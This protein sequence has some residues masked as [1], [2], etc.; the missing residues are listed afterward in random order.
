MSD[1]GNNE[2]ENMQDENHEPAANAQTLVTYLVKALVED[3]DAVKVDV[4]DVGRKFVLD[5]RVG[6]G[7][8]GKVIGKQGRTIKAIRTVARAAAVRDNVQVDVDIDD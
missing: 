4:R 1:P 5:V 6:E 7:E 3:T 8:T 2:N